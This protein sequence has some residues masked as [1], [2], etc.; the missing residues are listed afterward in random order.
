MSSP[1]PQNEVNKFVADRQAPEAISVP[2]PAGGWDG[3]TNAAPPP[4]RPKARLAAPLSLGPFESGK[5]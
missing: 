1:P 5:P 3:A 2:E 4:P